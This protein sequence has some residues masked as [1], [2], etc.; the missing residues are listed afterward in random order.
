[1][2]DEPPS[3]ATADEGQMRPVE[4][5]AREAGVQVRVVPAVDVLAALPERAPGDLRSC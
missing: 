5:S 4:S 1:M 2:D 3:V